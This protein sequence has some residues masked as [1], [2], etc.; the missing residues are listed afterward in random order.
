MNLLDAA[1]N[2]PDL[3]RRMIN[4]SSAVKPAV[5]TSPQT[6]T[7]FGKTDKQKVKRASIAGSLLG[8][9]AAVGGVYAIAKHKNPLTTLKNL[10]YQEGDILLVGAGSV[11]GGLAGGLISD[12]NKEN[13]NPKLREASQQ[14]FGNMCCPIG[15][16]AVASKL[17]DK[18]GFKLPLINSSTKMAQI[19]N[20]AIS[21]LPK[22]AVTV[23]SLVCGM[24]LGNK[25]M[26]N[27]NNKIF[28]ED[29]KHD[30]HAED[31]LVHTD[32]L[33]IAA[34]LILKDTKVISKFTSKILPF[35][36][37]VAGSKTGMQTKEDAV[38]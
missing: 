33:C 11:L 19:A 28:K 1:R 2:N 13:K 17:L 36:F 5:N 9:L 22:A 6:N 8:I 30:V 12:K 3:Y 20:N 16:L 4:K 31:Y 35:T 14:F 37:V 18:S 29:V 21:Y 7:S 34:N 10:N 32:D 26:N 27:V 24:E 25:I 23:A 38:H 15:I